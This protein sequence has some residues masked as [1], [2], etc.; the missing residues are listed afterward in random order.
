MFFAGEGPGDSFLRIEFL[1]LCRYR[2]HDLQ[3][4]CATAGFETNKYN[5]LKQIGNRIPH[6]LPE[7]G[8]SFLIIESLILTLTIAYLSFEWNFAA[9]SGKEIHD[10]TLLIMSAAAPKGAAF[11]CMT[12]DKKY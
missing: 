9:K 4:V 6:P 1:I 7:T 10:P 3:I 5:L 11:L 8:D 2:M 12:H